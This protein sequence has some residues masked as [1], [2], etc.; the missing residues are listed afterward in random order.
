MLYFFVYMVHKK[1]FDA[2]KAIKNSD[3]SDN[4]YWGDE[5]SYRS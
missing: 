2:C 5:I 4:V 3:K 1:D